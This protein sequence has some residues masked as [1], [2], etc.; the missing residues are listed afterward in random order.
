M[1]TFVPVA[2]L[3]GNWRSGTI[4]NVNVPT[5][6]AGVTL[7]TVSDPLPWVASAL[8]LPRGERRVYTADTS[9]T[10]RPALYVV[11]PCATTSPQI[12]IE[13]ELQTGAVSLTAEKARS[14]PL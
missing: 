9:G 5:T 7:V 6:E 12:R 8:Q 2:V 10:I 3:P 14:A 4:W 11:G 13:K 1:A